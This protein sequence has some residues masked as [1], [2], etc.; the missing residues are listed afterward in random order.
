MDVTWIPG[1]VDLLVISG[2]IVALAGAGVVWGRARRGGGRTSAP[3]AAPPQKATNEAREAPEAADTRLNRLRSRLGG[4]LGKSLQS[5]FS[6][7]AMGESEW[8][9][10]E[11]ILL[12][13]DVGPESTDAILAR[14]REVL[15]RDKNVTPKEAL[16]AELVAMVDPALDRHLSL[17]PAGAGRA[18]TVIVVGVNGVGKTTTVG[19]LAR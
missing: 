1:D 5:V 7:G 8:D 19:K 17:D 14:L 13:A 2:L 18:A 12:M 9:E 4:G 10:L 6:R 3:P 11:E 16:R 15:K